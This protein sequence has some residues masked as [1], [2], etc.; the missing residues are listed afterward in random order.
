MVRLGSVS[1]HE[2]RRALEALFSMVPAVMV[3]SL[4]RKAMAKAAWEAIAAAW[5]GSNRAHRSAL[6]KLREEW[7]R[8]A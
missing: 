5:V 7:D 3:P 4:L 2:D 8:L 6:Q 1:H